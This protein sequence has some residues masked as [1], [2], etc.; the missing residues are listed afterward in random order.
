MRF[1]LIY[2]KCVSV[3]HISYCVWY[4]FSALPCSNSNLD[5]SDSIALNSI[6]T[7]KF[8]RNIKKIVAPFK[9]CFPFARILF[10][11]IDLTGGRIGPYFPESYF[12]NTHI[13]WWFKA[14]LRLAIFK[15]TGPDLHAYLCYS[16]ET[17]ALIYFQSDFQSWSLWKHPLWDVHATILLQNALCISQ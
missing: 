4:M 2:I 10:S 3:I 14:Q 12:L 9:V 1:S 11:N 6:N 13:G 7:W 16:P 15:N 8:W 5:L 17:C